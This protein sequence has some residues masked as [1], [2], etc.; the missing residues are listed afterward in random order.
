MIIERLEKAVGWVRCRLGY[1]EMR[2]IG[3]CGYYT[4]HVGCLR[5]RKQWGMNHDVR[6]ILPWG[7]VRDFH[8]QNLHYDEAEA[9][10]GWNAALRARESQGDEK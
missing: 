7:V 9:L 5:C 8:I 1:H 3:R 10:V 2:I 4:D 6:A